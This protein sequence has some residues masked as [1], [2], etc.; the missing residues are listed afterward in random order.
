MID[1][2]FACVD[3]KIYLDCGG[4]W[5][6][7]QLEEPKTL[8]RNQAA[9]IEAVLTAE[10]Y[11][12]PPRNEQSQWLY[13]EVFPP[14]HTFLREHRDHEVVFGEKDYFAPLNDESYFEWM[15]VGYAATLSPR[16]FVEVLRF[17]D[18]GQVR[19]YVEHLDVRPAWW[20]VTWTDPSPHEQA[21]RKF[22][23]L[24]KRSERQNSNEQTP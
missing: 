12:N 8:V 10:Q 23:E 16:Y 11:W 3:C 5:A 2:F 7:W 21:R 15:Q 14:L 1:L 9:D 17:R 20:E 6:Y 13:K 18:W 19:E 22:D 24:V 4:R